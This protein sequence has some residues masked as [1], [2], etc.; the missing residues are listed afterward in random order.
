VRNIVCYHAKCS[1]GFTAAFVA[2]SWA[3]ERG[4][5]D[6]YEFV[7]TNPNKTPLVDVDGCNVIMFDVCL[8][9]EAL[10]KWKEL[11][12]HFEVYDHHIS[13]Q[14]EVGYLNYC[15]FDNNL[16][17][18]TLAWK[19]YYPDKEVPWWVAYTQD[20][21]L[22]TWKLP[23]SKE[24]SSF[25]VNLDFTFE[26][27]EILNSISFEEAL[28]IGSAILSADNVKIAQSCE[29]PMYMWMDEY[30]FMYDDYRGNDLCESGA[31]IY[32]IPVV[33]SNNYQSEI[34][35][36][37]AENNLFSIVWYAGEAED[38][39]KHA[40]L[41][42]RSVGDFDVS[43]IAKHFCGG[44][45]KNASGARVPLGNWLRKLMCLC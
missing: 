34:G 42:F 37:L 41:S 38:K 30:G 1:D 39:S 7:P 27:Y 21:D 18:A 11:T 44:G 6:S 33:N 43:L 2:Y 16:S 26:S 10:H 5:L 23:Q 31:K 35:N 8:E 20:R 9:K 15:H 12:N 4:I 40:Q 19:Y 17:G 29:R 32:K 25:L 13:N 22:W 28:K 3:R 14:R 24:I 45:H 36:K